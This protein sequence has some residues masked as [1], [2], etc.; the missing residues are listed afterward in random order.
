MAVKAVEM[1]RK[2]RDKHYK[3]TKDMSVQEQIDFVRKK[4][5]KLLQREK[6]G[7]RS[8]EKEKVETVKV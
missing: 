6:T 1:T 5:E 3:Q 7:R 2:I 4:S 8:T